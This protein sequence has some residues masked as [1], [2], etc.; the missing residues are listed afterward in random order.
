MPRLDGRALMESRIPQVAGV[1]LAAGWGLLEFT[2]WAADRGLIPPGLVDSVLVGWIVLLPVVLYGSWRAFHRPA[3]ARAAS[4]PDDASV[5]VLPFENHSASGDDAYLGDG[6]T[7]EI[8]TALTRINGLRVAS[9]TST[10]ALATRGDVREIGRALHVGSVLEGE[11]QRAGDRLRVSTRLVNVA[12]GYQLWAGRYDGDMEDVFAIQDQIAASV[13]QALEALLGPQG[14]RGLRRAHRTD[15]RA[16]ELYLRGRQFFHQTRR[17]S[18]QFARSMFRK[19]LEIDPEYAPALAAL[20]DAIALERTYYPEAEVHWAEADQAS[21]RAL[22][23]DPDLPEAHSARGLVLSTAGRPEEAEAAFRRAIELDPR[24]VAAHYFMGRMLFQQGRFE[25]AAAAFDAA[26]SI[27]NDHQA[28]FFAAQAYEALGDE[29]RAS[30]HYREALDEVAR[31]MELN[32][33]DARAATMRAVAL[34]RIDRREEGLDWGRRAVE[35]DPED[36][37]VR[38]NLACLYSVAGELD[39]SLDTLESA[40]D[41]GF[42]NRGWLERDPDLS[43]I[44]SHPRFRALLERTG[45]PDEAEEATPPDAEDATPADPARGRAGN[46]AS[47]EEVRPG[48]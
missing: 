20:A 4:P 44:R 22:E 12:D 32:P 18:L 2:S 30:T 39:R 31:H 27:R 9:R 36:A 34:C 11:V 1:Y 45:P 40:I 43:A 35:I 15:V 14:S 29:E 24:L 23:L 17:K 25:D 47:G 6:V 13:A 38:Y 19:A 7:D 42:G 10:R 33:D 28:A 46:G 16:Y 3:A 8:T 37:S 41:V 21:R 5:A 48:G 26:V